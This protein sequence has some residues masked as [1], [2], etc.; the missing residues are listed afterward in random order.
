MET[1]IPVFR[2]AEMRLTR[3]IIRFMQEDVV[4]ATADVNLIR[5]RAGN[6]AIKAVT[7]ENIQNER[8]KEM[9]QEG[10]RPDDVRALKQPI[11][12]GDLDQCMPSSTINYLTL[13]SISIFRRQRM[14]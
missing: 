3:A 8:I 14:I 12:P 1:N 6:E 9:S 7:E 5:T 11:L 4:G 13:I 2:L 10:N